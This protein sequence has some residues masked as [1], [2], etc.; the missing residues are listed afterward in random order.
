M[1][2]GITAQYIALSID[3]TGGQNVLRGRCVKCDV[4]NAISWELGG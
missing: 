2:V 1:H 4:S 3:E